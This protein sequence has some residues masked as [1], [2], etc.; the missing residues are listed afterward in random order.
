MRPAPWQ[1]VGTLAALGLLGAACGPGPEGEGTETAIVATVGDRTIDVAEF[2]DELVPAVGPRDLSPVEHRRLALDRIIMLELT[3]RVARRRGL[4][5]DPRY[6]EILRL[7]NR[8]AHRRKQNALRQVLSEKMAADYSPSEEA[9]RSYHREHGARFRTTRVHLAEIVTE[10]EEAANVALEEIRSGTAFDEVARTRSLAAS[11][12][13]GGQIGPYARGLVPAHLVQQARRLQ[14][15]GDLEGP[16]ET[17]DGWTIVRLE[18]RET[19][20][21]R[22]FEE[23]RSAIERILRREEMERRFKTTLAEER[24]RIGVSVNEDV[25]IDDTLFETAGPR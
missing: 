22:E 5:T 7:I 17:P 19:N 3:D 6:L 10:T 9:I 14:D 1:A 2:R 24:D 8:D 25:L 12:T 13:R 16:F 11:A 20:V 15:P 21:P 23:V 18:G 4:A